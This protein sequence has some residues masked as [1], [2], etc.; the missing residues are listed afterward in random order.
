M[1]IHFDNKEVERQAEYLLDKAVCENKSSFWPPVENNQN[2][3]KNLKSMV[4]RWNENPEIILGDARLKNYSYQPYVSE[5]KYS[6]FGDEKWLNGI[7]LVAM[8]PAL[9][10]WDSCSIH[11]LL[12]NQIHSL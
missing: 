4:D 2:L 11:R 12:L 8:F 5:V 1:V 7:F 6:T 10:D 9:Y 3:F